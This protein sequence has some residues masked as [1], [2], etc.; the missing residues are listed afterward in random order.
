[1]K[2]LKII[3]ATI[4]MVLLCA[5]MADAQTRK[6]SSSSSK[7]KTTATAASKKRAAEAKDEAREESF[8]KTKMWYGADVNYPTLYNGFFNMSINP[9]AAYKVTNWLS[10]GVVLKGDYTYR[11]LDPLQNAGFR[12]YESIDYGGGIF[13]RAKI[14]SGLFAHVEYE[15]S[16][17]KINP[18]ID[19]NTNKIVTQTVVQPYAYVG[20]GWASGMGKWQT[21]IAAYRNVL[22][23]T[24]Y[25][26]GAW[27]LKF[28]LLYNF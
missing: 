7:K 19:L 2:G 22:D 26:R 16:V 24:G 10:T 23:A 18:E 27:D 12:K 9:R 20:L 6:K 5:S 14:F 13:A 17:F 8:W 11:K 28:G 15:R 25:V 1:M 21:Q 4:M 3:F